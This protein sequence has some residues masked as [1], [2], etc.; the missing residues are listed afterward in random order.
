[1]SY[2]SDY[3]YREQ[4][5]KSAG[6]AERHHP[7]DLPSGG[8]SAKGLLI[9]AIAIVAFIAFVALVSV[10]GGSDGTAPSVDGETTQTTPEAGT[11][12]ETAPTTAPATGE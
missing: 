7:M 12:I 3:R 1:M 11:A 2:E 9:A 5:G 8:G 10:G 6:R 4:A